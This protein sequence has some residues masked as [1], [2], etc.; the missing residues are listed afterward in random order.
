MTQNISRRNTAII[1]LAIVVGIA[2]MII[3]IYYPYPSGQLMDVKGFIQLWFRELLILGVF[4]IA[5]IYSNLRRH[6]E[7]SEESSKPRAD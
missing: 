3:S 1:I 7:L 6:S 5:L 2:G 4:I